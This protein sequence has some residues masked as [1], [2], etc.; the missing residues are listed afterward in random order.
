[1]DFFD[2]LGED[3]L[4]LVEKSRR[5]GRVSGELNDTFVVLIHKSDK[6][7]SFGWFIP[8]S[9][10]NLVYKIISKI[11]AVKIKISLSLGISKEQFGFLE[12]R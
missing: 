8:I 11:I 5:K 3:I 10:C 12:G 1:L 2:L 7:D 9:I 6:P 4:G